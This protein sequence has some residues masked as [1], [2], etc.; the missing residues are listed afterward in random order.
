MLKKM[1][2]VMG[3]KVQRKID[4]DLVEV[5]QNLKKLEM[6]AKSVFKS[7]GH[8]KENGLNFKRL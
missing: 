5:H 2:L 8:K 6:K 3:K 1:S 4:E 7:Q